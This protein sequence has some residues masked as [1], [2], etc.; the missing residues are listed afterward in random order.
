MA[1][2]N[3]KGISLSDQKLAIGSIN[4][5]EKI[6]KFI[7]KKKYSQKDF[8]N[9][10]SKNKIMAALYRRGFSLSDIKSVIDGLVNKR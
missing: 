2:L 7:D 1:E 10:L 5:K 4:D 6:T 8:M 3:Q 9:P